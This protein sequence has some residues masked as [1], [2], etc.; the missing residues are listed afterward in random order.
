[1][2][3]C[4]SDS[5]FLWITALYK[6][7]FVLYC[8]CYYLFSWQLLVKHS[9]CPSAIRGRLLY[10]TLLYSTS[11]FRAGQNDAVCRC[12]WDNKLKLLCLHTAEWFQRMVRMLVWP[13]ERLPDRQVRAETVCSPKVYNLAF[14]LLNLVMVGLK[15]SVKQWTLFSKILTWAAWSRVLT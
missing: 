4:A 3:T 5:F 14:S 11:G 15:S 10:L 6:F 8:I 12:L 9:L 13:A 1:M 7:L 2:W